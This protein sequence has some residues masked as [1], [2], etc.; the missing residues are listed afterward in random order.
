MTKT[1]LDYVTALGAVAT[2][3]L[4]LALTALGWRI[5]QR[6]ERKQE[7]EDALREGRLETYDTILEPFTILMTPDAVWR[8]DPKNRNQDRVASATRIVQSIEYRKAAFRL[9]LFAADPVIRAYNE[10]YQYLAQV[11][12]SGKEADSPEIM[13]RLGAFLLEIRRSVGID[14]E[15]DR[16]EMLEWFLPDARRLRQGRRESAEPIASADAPTAARG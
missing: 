14:T 12:L 10:F 11:K 1:W 5:R 6:L 2:P 4:V 13:G 7:L 15:L 9:S 16:F 8:A 3:I